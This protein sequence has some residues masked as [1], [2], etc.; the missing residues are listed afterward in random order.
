MSVFDKQCVSL[1]LGV[2]YSADDH[3][4]VCIYLVF[5]KQCVSLVLGGV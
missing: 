4:D 2:V 3:M 5:D 1:V